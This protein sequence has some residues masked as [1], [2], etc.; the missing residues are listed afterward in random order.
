MDFLRAFRQYDPATAL[1]VASAAVGIGT[2][3]YGGMSQQKAAKE[4]AALVAKQ[5]DVAFEEARVSAADEARAQTHAVQRQKL[6]FLSSGVSLEGSPLMV[7][8][9]S[10][11]YGQQ[12]VDAILRQGSARK[13]LAY[14]QASQLKKKGRAALITGI[15]EG[16]SKAIGTGVDMNKAGAFQSKAVTSKGK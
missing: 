2:S 6:A 4:E 10:R 16:V 7:L 13:E 8:N 11:E 3:V 15:G 5:G 9:E 1:M 14:S 12:S